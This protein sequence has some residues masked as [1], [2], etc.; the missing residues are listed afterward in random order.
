MKKF[1][2]Y[3]KAHV[4]QIINFE[5]KKMIP[6]TDKECESYA[7][8]EYCHISRKIVKEEDADDKKFH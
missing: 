3:L 6:V 2:E 7:S 8:Q 1:C 5:K 4:M